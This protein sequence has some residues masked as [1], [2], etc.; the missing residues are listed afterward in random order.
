MPPSLN[1]L[2]TNM[3]FLDIPNGK[4]RDAVVTDYLATVNRIKQRN[5]NDKAKDL[6]RH[7]VGR[8][9]SNRD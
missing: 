4:K 9:V 5:L 7:R 1:I 3:S 2:E 6:G 8:V